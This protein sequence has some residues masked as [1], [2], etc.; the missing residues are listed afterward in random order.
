[1]KKGRM[2]IVDR[3]KR[4]AMM[5]AVGRSGTAP[6]I[7]VHQI[8]KSAGLRVRRNVRKL[9]GSPDL[10]IH[11]ARLAIFVHGC[12]WHNHKGCKRATIPVSNR[13]FWVEKFEKNSR[14][15]T[16]KIDQL[17]TSGWRV[18]VIW[19]CALQSPDIGVSDKNSKRIV[20]FILGQRR[21]GQIPSDV[22][23]WKNS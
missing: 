19:E 22:R 11:T 18:L 6:E 8:V 13:E 2:D 16:A 4:S 20:S 14:R 3:S 12:F 1:M 15:D 23:P 5:R 9:P 21:K 10:V 7:A 17:L